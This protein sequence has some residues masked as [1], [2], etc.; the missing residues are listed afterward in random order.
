MYN[1]VYRVFKKVY[2]KVKRLNKERMCVPRLDRDLIS[3]IRKMTT[4]IILLHIVIS[5]FIH[6]PS[7]IGERANAQSNIHALSESGKE[8]EEIQQYYKLIA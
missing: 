4:M 2:W 5:S 7:P 1:S 3:Q 6:V 8:H